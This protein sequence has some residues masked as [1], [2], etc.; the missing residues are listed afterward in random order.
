MSVNNTKLLVP[1]L[2]LFIAAAIMSCRQDPLSP[3]VEYMP[4]MYRTPARKAYVNYDF[5]DSMMA[6]MP[7]A[8][9]IPY[10]ESPDGRYDNL[11]YPFPNTAEG[12]EAAGSQLK[13]PVALTDFTLD[14]GKILYGKYCI[15]CHGDN[16]QGDG[17]LVQRDKFPP[18]PAYNGAQLKDLPE[19]KMFHTVTYG[20]G[21]MGS[22]A[23]QLSKT[24]RWKIIHY[25]QKLQRQE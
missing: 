17:T 2:L 22:H 4:D 6:R 10:S 25:V 18:P 20:K 19:G 13:N 9:T 11:P 5:P 3:G 7:V 14:E 8:G 21:L 23:S 24:E 16:G 1:G 12:Y 15:M